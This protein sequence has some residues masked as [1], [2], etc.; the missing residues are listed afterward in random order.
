METIAFPCM[1]RHG[2]AMESPWN[3]HGMISGRLA[4]GAWR[5]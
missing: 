3:R 5:L 1:K 4:A 2:I